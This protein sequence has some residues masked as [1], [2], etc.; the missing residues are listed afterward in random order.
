MR[1]DAVI[2]RLE[3]ALRDPLPGL[4][5][6]STM[7]PR[8]RGGWTPGREPADIR[9]AAGLLLVVPRGAHGHVVLTVRGDSVRHAGQVSLPGGAVEPGETFEQTALREAYEEVGLVPD[10]VEIVG[11][12]TPLA[13][14]VSG[15]SLHP[16]VAAARAGPGLRASDGE[17]ARIVEAPIRELLDPRRILWRSMIRDGV[18]IDV[19]IFATRD[20]EIWGA[21][22]M[23]L[24]EFLKLLDWAGP[25]PRPPDPL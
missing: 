2:A 8:P 6:Q 19:P 9:H 1:F 14:P 4:P 25:P 7:A 15:F 18:T 20:V 21:T 24:A 17:V 13:I 22:A 12:L 10:K 11:R 16:I 3:A 5:A 23:V